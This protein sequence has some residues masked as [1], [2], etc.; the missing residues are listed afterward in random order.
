MDIGTFGVIWV[1]IWVSEGQVNTAGFRTSMPK[2][3]NKAFLPFLS[4]TRKRNSMSTECSGIS[5][6]EGRGRLW[7]DRERPGWFARQ[8]KPQS[9][10]SVEQKMPFEAATMRQL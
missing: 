1:G 9:P 3:F 5:G 8:G 10:P 7:V 2:D 4:Y 6:V